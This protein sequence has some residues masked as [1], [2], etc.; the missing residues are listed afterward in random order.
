MIWE[1]V[2]TIRALP[3]APWAHATKPPSISVGRSE[4]DKRETL[5]HGGSNEEAAWSEGL[6]VG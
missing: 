4:V 5:V 3:E 6:R 2:E 1:A